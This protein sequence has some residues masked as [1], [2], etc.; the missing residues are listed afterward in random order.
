MS[1]QLVWVV[2]QVQTRNVVLGDGQVVGTHELANGLRKP[3][4]T[5]LPYV[6][7]KSHVVE[8]WPVTFGVCPISLPDLPGRFWL[9]V[10]TGLRE[11]DIVLLTNHVL[12]TTLDAEYIVLAY[13]RR[14]GCEEGTRCWKQ[15]TGVED[16]RV[17]CWQSIQRLTF[18]AML[19][20]G[21][22]ALWLLTRPAVAKQLIAR[23][24][25]FIAQVL[26]Q[27]YR[28]WEGT[29]DALLHEA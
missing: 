11:E 12:R 5:A 4:T 14:W 3:H 22:Q 26:F 21:I 25:V 19:A 1:L 15:K 7:K 6:C 2:R 23:V 18:L 29:A 28:L 8:H 13:A 9:V 24:K 10:I 17:R 27:H 16:F 20:Y